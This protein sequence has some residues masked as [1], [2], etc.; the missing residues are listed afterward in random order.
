MRSPWI[1]KE[2]QRN[3]VEALKSKKKKEDGIKRPEA[4]YYTSKIRFEK[5]QSLRTLLKEKEIETSIAQ[6]QR[7]EGKK[8]FD[9]K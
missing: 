9:S 2:E 7:E 5:L 8:V 4:R 6:I 1:L 3:L